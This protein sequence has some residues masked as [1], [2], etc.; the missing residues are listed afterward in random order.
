MRY[1]DGAAWTD[2]FAPTDPPSAQLI[3]TGS[4]A[5]R[6]T[7]WKRKRVWIPA[8]AFLGILA[9]GST[10]EDPATTTTQVGFAADSSLEPVPTDPETTSASVE[11]ATPTTAAPTT[12]TPT[13]ATPTTEL[14][15]P[16]T[17]PAPDSTF[18]VESFMAGNEEILRTALLMTGNTTGEPFS[19]RQMDSAV[20]LTKEFCRLAE[21]K[22]AREIVTEALS[23][24]LL[25]G[26]TDAARVSGAA[27]GLAPTYCPEH[28][29]VLKAAL[30]LASAG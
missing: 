16:T 18:N 15:P 25:G 30:A 29:T 11:T 17:E 2:Q 10:V 26:T 3:A 12:A 22:T 5:A 13:T 4:T 21:T 14:A 1:W 28:S 6:K 20:A 24:A 7:W 23:G 8:A 9:I 19:E 27:L